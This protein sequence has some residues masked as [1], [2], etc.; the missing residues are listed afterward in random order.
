MKPKATRT[1]KSQWTP[2]QWVELERLAKAQGIPVIAL[3]VDAVAN[4]YPTFPT[5]RR[6]DGVRDSVKPVQNLNK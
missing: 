4:K 2:E 3:L 1:Y 5:E 6:E